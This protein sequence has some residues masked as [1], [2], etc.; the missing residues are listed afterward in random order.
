MNR[1]PLAFTLGANA[2]GFLFHPGAKRGMI[3]D[4]IME[5]EDTPP[6]TAQSLDALG[7]AQGEIAETL[8]G[9]MVGLCR[10]AALA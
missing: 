4:L 3:E 6:D 7:R 9:F 1:A 5:F 8:T 10:F 2:A